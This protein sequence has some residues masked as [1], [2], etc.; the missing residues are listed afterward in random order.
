VAKGLD[1]FWADE[2]H[3]RWDEVGKKLTRKG[4]EALGVKG[5]KV[6]VEGAGLRNGEN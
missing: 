1:A 5:A 4:A 3:L 6:V 2:T